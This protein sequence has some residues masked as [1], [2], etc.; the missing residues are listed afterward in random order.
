MPCK[1]VSLLGGALGE[2][3]VPCLLTLYK[4]GNQVVSPFG[5]T[6]LTG[7]VIQKPGAALVPAANGVVTVQEP[8]WYELELEGA[9]TS[10]LGDLLLRV[11]RTT[12][13][14]P[15]PIPGA[16]IHTGLAPA[17][18]AAVYRQVHEFTAGEAFRP[19]ARSTGGFLTTVAN[20]TVLRVSGPWA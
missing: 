14:G 20:Q 7:W 11:N 6:N 2:I 16:I 4:S 3:V 18:A 5:W 19:Q 1:A 10:G 15:L 12:G 17:G 13:G 9:Y 8:G